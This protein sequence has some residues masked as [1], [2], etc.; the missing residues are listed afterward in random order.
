MK[1]MLTKAIIEMAKG[2]NPRTLNLVDKQT[3]TKLT[4]D[5]ISIVDTTI[6]VTAAERTDEVI[7]ESHKAGDYL[8]PNINI[9]GVMNYSHRVAISEDK[10]KSGKYLLET[11]ADLSWDEENLL[12]PSVY[13]EK[14]DLFLSKCGF[15]TV[16]DIQISKPIRT[17][18]DVVYVLNKERELVEI[19]D[20]DLEN[21]DDN[22]IIEVDDKYYIAE[23]SNKLMLVEDATPTKER[24]LEAQLLKLRPKFNVDLFCDYENK[25]Y[26]EDEVIQW[27]KTVTENSEK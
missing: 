12:A 4:K 19:S 16:C 1:T 22:D 20:Q 17:W 15:N 10:A 11:D 23:L 9:F 5:G 18:G 25:L 27:A 21:I 3:G 7:V 8:R 26:T 13:K 2:T 14:L 24:L 6:A